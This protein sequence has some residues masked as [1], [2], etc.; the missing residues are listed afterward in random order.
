MAA[1]IL[2]RTK[3][4]QGAQLAFKCSSEFFHAQNQLRNTKQQQLSPTP[5]PVPIWFCS[6]QRHMEQALPTIFHG[7]AN[8][9]EA[10]ANPT[11]QLGST[12][13]HLFPF[14]SIAVCKFCVLKKLSFLFS[15]FLLTGNGAYIWPV[16]T[17]GV[18]ILAAL[19]D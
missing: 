2:C 9:A 18:A 13:S 12:Y 11:I 1:T 6:T 7:V 10:A 15:F 8:R 4:E 5:E 17:T 3:L 16:Y 14:A 19:R